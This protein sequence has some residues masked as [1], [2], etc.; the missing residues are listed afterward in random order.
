MEHTHPIKKPETD[1]RHEYRDLDT[2][3]NT[4]EIP[5][6]DI[7]PTPQ[8]S[9]LDARWIDAAEQLKIA[10]SEDEDE[11]T[12]TE[13]SDKGDD[14][15]VPYV[16]GTAFKH[17]AHEEVTI[18]PDNHHH[19][20]HHAAPVDVLP[21]SPEVVGEKFRGDE[22]KWEFRRFLVGALSIYFFV[23]ITVFTSLS[24]TFFMKDVLKLPP[25]TAQTISAFGDLPWM[26]KPVF[27]AISDFL[28]I[29]GLRRRPYLV[30]GALLCAIGYL[31]IARVVHT[32]FGIL[33]CLITANAGIVF[34]DV[35][36][37]S[38]VVER[39]GSGSRH[40][41]SLQ[42]WG[43]GARTIGNILASYS[44]GF[45]LDYVSPQTVFGIGFTFPV[46]LLFASSVI[47]EEPVQHQKHA[48]RDVAHVYSTSEPSS[49]KV[50]V[51]VK[52][53]FHALKEPRVWRAALFIFL[54]NATPSCDTPM[55]FF[56]VNV[57]KMPSEAF[58][59]RDLLT[60]I[61]SLFGIFA[62]QKYLR[63]VCLRKI[64]LWTTIVGTVLQ[65]SS[66]LLVT[67]WSASLH[68]SDRV[69]LLSNASMVAVLGQIQLMPVLVLAAKICPKG[70]EG[71]MFA[72]LMS[73]KNTA[74][75][76]SVFTGGILTNWLNVT[77]TN[78][79][80]LWLLIAICSLS[81]PIPLVLLKWVPSSSGPAEGHM[82]HH[83]HSGAPSETDP[84]LP[85]SSSSSSLAKREQHD[86]AVNVV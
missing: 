80:N 13:S 81:S 65:L 25:D 33:V 49:N 46:L 78:F 55:L 31:S 42:S 48:H 68:I 3:H 56:F 10:K 34:S 5:A 29:G 30:V 21:S 85:S 16:L 52:R 7:P 41:S 9:D 4:P 23:G 14:D 71:T 72:L 74:A 82:H 53:V 24:V 40:H 6:P 22:T 26:V 39:I 37:D 1:L 47:Q 75:F 27:G 45:I 12:F 28:P 54:V 62:F 36:A 2:A 67:G 83:K 84:L 70:I 18:I 59:T 60:S 19:H 69:F 73:I 38:L 44:G 58:G 63:H 35:I 79:S 61:A 8:D 50:L 57:L 17:G 64:L 43:W 11:E 15:D 20:H 66:I 32:V 86:H 77:P 51:L 76:T